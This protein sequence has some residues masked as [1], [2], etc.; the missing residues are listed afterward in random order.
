MIVPLHALQASLCCMT[1]AIVNA[2][3]YEPICGMFLI[4]PLCG[5]ACNA[6][7]DPT[8]NRP[9]LVNAAK[10]AMSSKILGPESS[11]FAEMAVDAVTAVRTESAGDLGKK[12]SLPPPLP[13]NFPARFWNTQQ[14]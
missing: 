11:F 3:W 10:T 1:P 8:K 13:S 12:A 2:W 4:R 7:I 5:S 9:N 14:Q 6:T